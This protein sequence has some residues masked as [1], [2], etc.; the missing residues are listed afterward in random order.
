[1]DRPCAG[2][3]VLTEDMH[4][5]QLRLNEAAATERIAAAFPALAEL[6]V[7]ALSTPGTVN[8]LFRIGDAHVARFPLQSAPLDDVSAEARAL[9]EFATCSPFPAPVVD[10]VVD[11]DEDYPSAWSVQTWIPG[12]T[13][14]ETLSE[15]DPGALPLLADDLARLI[16]ALRLAP[17]RGRTF[18]GRGRG[19]ELHAHE[20]WMAECFAR[21]G[22]LL[23]VPAAR[24]LW[25]RL[26]RIPHPGTE[27]MSHKDLIPPNL[28]VSDDHR[29][30]GGPG[31]RILRSRGSVARSRGRVAPARTRRP[32]P[33]PRRAGLR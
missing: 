23:D 26:S 21:S 3:R 11:R 9:D 14:T 32:A 7:H 18:D 28:L 17:L 15:E 29:L 31:R 6:P 1:M 12:R 30:A 5:D 22:H 8:A 4:P 24:A 25:E 2:N 20:E 16:D 19:G 33:A 10:G 27:V 13:A